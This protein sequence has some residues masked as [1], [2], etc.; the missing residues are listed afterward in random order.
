MK[1]LKMLG[2]LGLF[3]LIGCTAVTTVETNEV[4]TEIDSAESNNAQPEAMPV[5][6]TPLPEPT[7]HRRRRQTTL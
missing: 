3:L 5:S 7:P 6:E 1:T 4:E 2:C